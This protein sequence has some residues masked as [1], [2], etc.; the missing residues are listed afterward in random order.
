MGTLSPPDDVGD[1]QAVGVGPSSVGVPGAE[2]VGDGV[3]KDDAAGG[4]DCSA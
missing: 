4:R 3:S 2:G 1:N